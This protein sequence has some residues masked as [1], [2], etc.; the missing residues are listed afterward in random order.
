MLSSACIIRAALCH[1]TMFL[2]CRILKVSMIGLLTSA[3]GMCF[4]SHPYGHLFANFHM[5]SL[6]KHFWNVSRIRAFKKCLYTVNKPFLYKTKSHSEF[7]QRSNVCP[8]IVMLYHCKIHRWRMDQLFH[9]LLF[10]FI[11]KHISCRLICFIQTIGD[12]Y[13]NAQPWEVYC[14]Y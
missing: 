12:T 5:V 11:L 14:L 2:M 8:S 3:T 6:I 4:P 13:W 1:F 10:Y 9:T 7:C